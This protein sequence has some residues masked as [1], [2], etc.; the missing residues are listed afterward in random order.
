M[1]KSVVLFVSAVVSYN[2]FSADYLTSDVAPYVYPENKSEVPAGFSYAADGNGCYM[3]SSDHKTIDRY[4]I[5]TGK[6]IET[7]FD[8]DRVRET[9]ID[10]IEGFEVC[11]NGRY[12]LVYRDSDPIYR[13]SFTANYYIYEVR[14]RLLRPLSYDFQRQRA[15]LMTDDGRMVAF[16]ADDNNIYIKKVDYDSQVAVTT[17]GSVNKIINGVPDWVY[18]EEFSTTCSMVWSPD[19]LTLCFLKYDEAEVPMYTLPVYEGT[20]DPKKEYALY[21]GMYSYKYPM[22]GV[23]NSKVTLHA[24]GVETRKT[25]DITLPDNSIE[26]IPRIA[27]GAADDRLLVS[28]LNRDQNK[29]VIYDVNPRSAV[30][31]SVYV[32]N[33]KAWIEE[34]CYDDIVYGE[35]YF[36]VMS[37]RSGFN[38]YYRYAYNGTLQKSLTS[39]DYDATAFY[40]YDANGNYYYQAASPSPLDRVVYK[41]DAKGKVTIISDKSGTNDARFSADMSYAMMVHSDVSTPPLYTINTSDGKRLRVLED[42]AKV[43]ARFSSLPKK[44]F[45][46]MTSDGVKLNGYIIKPAGFVDTQKY[47]TIMSQYSGPG[48]QQVL[49]R[50]SVDWEQYFATQGYVVVCVDGRGTGG[51][52]HDFMDVVYKRLGYYETIDQVNAAKYAASL[53][54]V[55]ASRIGIY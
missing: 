18:E 24:Y 15:P 10:D 4:D 48:S 25:V 33:A 38:H 9:S 27:Y 51:R 40:G 32:D 21:P 31:K 3:L 45:F 17:D 19:N 28:T 11:A 13:R 55:D 30:S 36:V 7:I 20:C 22:P 52:G 50:W 16:V 1:R 47:P 5:K 42:N 29:F 44:E 8:V 14:S 23:K 6:K 53:P 12:I 34:G 39:G 26:Y 49:N 46:T 37:A 2:A 35:D 54:Y 43:A 41:A